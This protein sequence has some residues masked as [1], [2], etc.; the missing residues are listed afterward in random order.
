MAL[1]P[2]ANEGTAS[3]REELQR[4]WTFC[5]DD[6]DVPSSGAPFIVN[7]GPVA[8]DGELEGPGEPNQAA[9]RSTAALAE[10]TGRWETLRV[11][12]AG[13]WS[14]NPHLPFKIWSNGMGH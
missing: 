11:R 3:S 13:H 10:G 9:F 12:E 7:A 1:K 5:G 14:G 2:G 8:D 6:Q 4:A